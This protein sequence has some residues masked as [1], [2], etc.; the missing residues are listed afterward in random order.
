VVKTRAGEVWEYIDPSL[1]ADEVQKL[2]AP[3]KPKPSDIKQGAVSPIDLNDAERKKLPELQDLV[4]PTL[5]EYELKKKAL[6]EMVKHIQETVPSTYLSWT[7][8]CDTVYD[9][10][11]ALQ[12]RLKP[13]KDVRQRELIEKLIKLRDN[14]KSHQID[15]WL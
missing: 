3:K 12:K 15:E 8:D 5:K 6:N 13:K 11:I 1:A 2:V 4:K 10:L 14:P 9:M 7:Y